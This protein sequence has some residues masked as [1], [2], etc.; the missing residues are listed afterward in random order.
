VSATIKFNV[1]AQYKPLYIY[2]YMY[3]F[4]ENQAID[5]I[6]DFANLYRNICV[7]KLTILSE[8][9]TDNR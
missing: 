5:V 8:N 1:A 9:I 6:R 2:I 7:G 3:S 4:D